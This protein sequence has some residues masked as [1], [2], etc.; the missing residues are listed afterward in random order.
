MT[1]FVLFFVEPNLLK[2]GDFIIWQMNS[3]FHILFYFLL[4]RYVDVM[5]DGG[6]SG[7]AF[8]V[9]MFMQSAGKRETGGGEAV[10]AGSQDDGDGEEEGGRGRS[11][12]KHGRGGCIG[13]AASLEEAEGARD[14]RR[15]T[16]TATDVRHATDE[17]TPPAHVHERDV[18][19]R[20]ERRQDG[21]GKTP[22]KTHSL[23]GRQASGSLS[24]NW[25]PVSC[26]T[27]QAPDH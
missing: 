1:V 2:L 11:R 12:G 9:A 21:M 25:T 8:R 27:G 7:E 24:G 6:S 16:T 15:E 17:L 19:Q 13:W 14:S 18:E 3:L 5:K 22:R 20:M 26:V 23:T 10:V 4:L